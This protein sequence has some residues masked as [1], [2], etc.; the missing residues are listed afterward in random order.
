MVAF[1]SGDRLWSAE[2]LR[3]LD[4]RIAAYAGLGVKAIAIKVD[5]SAAELKA[6]EQ[7]T[8][9]STVVLRDE[10]GGLFSRVGRGHLPRV[11]LLDREGRV[12]W[13]DIEFS[14]LT[15]EQLEQAIA[16]SLKST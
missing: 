11:Y 7:E 6:G 12:L 9:G 10:Q 2:L 16:A 15:R 1:W 3:F 5:H 13:F 8:P 14:R 4:Q